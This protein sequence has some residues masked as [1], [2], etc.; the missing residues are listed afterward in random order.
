MQTIYVSFHISVGGGRNTQIKC[1]TWKWRFST[2]NKSNHNG[3]LQNHVYY[4]IIINE[5]LMC[6]MLKLLY[7]VYQNITSESDRI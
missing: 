3:L 7:T 5:E 1:Q 2:E 6:F 4:F